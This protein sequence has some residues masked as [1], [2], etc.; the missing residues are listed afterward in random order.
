MKTFATKP[1]KHALE[2]K[3]GTLGFDDRCKEKIKEFKKI[4]FPI[5][6]NYAGIGISIKAVKEILI[7]GIPTLQ[8]DVQALGR[9]L[10]SPYYYINPPVKI[11]N[12]TF[13]KENDG[14][15]ELDIENTEVNLL[16]ALKQFVGQTVEGDV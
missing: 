14:E 9:K 12:G 1:S 11:G 3:L 15:I 13:R 7:N 6:Y 10:R 2:T 16:E 5:D 8:V 4:L